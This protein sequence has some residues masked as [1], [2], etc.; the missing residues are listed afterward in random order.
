MIKMQKDS[1]DLD[2]WYLR[3][4]FE[5]KH[6]GYARHDKVSL[7][8]RTLALDLA[9]GLPLLSVKPTPWKSAIKE[10]AWFCSEDYDYASLE[11]AGVTWWRPWVQHEIDKTGSAHVVLTDEKLPY[12]KL[13]L[14]TKR[15]LNSLAS[16]DFDS[17][18]LYCSLWPEES[19]LGEA[20][21]PPCALAHQVTV[22]DKL[23]LTV[24]QR[25]ADMLCGVPTNLIQYAWLASIYARIAGKPLGTLQ[26]HFGD[27]HVYKQHLA[28]PEYDM[29]LDFRK[30]FDG[31]HSFVLPN[32][33]KLNSISLELAEHTA[34]SSN[35]RRQ[36]FPSFPVVLV[37]TN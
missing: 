17:T 32:F 18:R 33:S 31:V 20:V 5:L 1:H 16:G 27:L 30:D 25:S 37:H 15:I 36:P 19:K 21:L 9:S 24:Y 13:R 6:A 26:F 23:N 10:L 28:L 2:N 34:L 4:L 3:T 11:L 7:C 8:Q 12:K 35:Y 14:G 29:L 22:T